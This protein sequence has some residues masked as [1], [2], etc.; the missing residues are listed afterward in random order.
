MITKLKKCTRY[1]KLNMTNLTYRYLPR[2]VI[3]KLLLQIGIVAGKREKEKERER[4]DY[5]ESRIIRGQ[6]LTLILVTHGRFKCYA[7]P[8]QIDAYERSTLGARAPC[9]YIIREC[10]CLFKSRLS[11]PFL[12]I[13]R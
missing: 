1:Y 5:L 3:F 11:E 10:I 6:R 8:P 9:N 7:S 12:Q 13:I 4:A 2:F